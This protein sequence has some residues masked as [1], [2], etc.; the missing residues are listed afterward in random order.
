MGGR[1]PQGQT[2]LELMEIPD[3]II[4]YN[5]SEPFRSMSGL[6]NEQLSK[7]IHELDETNVW[8]FNRFS[9]PEYL[10]RRKVVE[11]RLR[12]EFISKGGRPLL[13]HPIY[14][15]LG[16]NADFERHERNKPYLV[17]LRDLPKGSVSFTYGDSMFSFNEDYRSLKSHA[18]QSELCPYVYMLEELPKIFSH[19]D[20]C[21]SAHLHIEA[22][23]WIRPSKCEQWL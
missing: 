22:Q 21:S 13:A 16:R 9:D 23:L 15:F 18:Y 14:F 1:V 10:K 17:R 20:F 4:H 19:K 2:G 12:K 5:R 11:E 6:S 8:G 7:V 3:F